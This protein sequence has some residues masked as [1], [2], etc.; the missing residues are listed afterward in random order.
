M[1]PARFIFSAGS[2]STDRKDDNYLDIYNLMSSVIQD[3]KDAIEALKALSVH[4][5]T[6][7]VQPEDQLLLLITCVE[8]TVER[9]VLAARR[10]RYGE[11]EDQLKALVN[12]SQKR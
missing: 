7:D 12:M 6:V 10:I 4:T 2:F 8:R 1:H 11:S 3:R 5:C 9:R